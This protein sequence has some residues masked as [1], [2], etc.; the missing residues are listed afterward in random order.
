MEL[1]FTVKGFASG[2][3]THFGDKFA[4]LAPLSDQM[5][6]KYKYNQIELYINIHI[7]IRKDILQK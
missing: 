5:I 6:H 3:E 1:A 2:I 4:L 7:C